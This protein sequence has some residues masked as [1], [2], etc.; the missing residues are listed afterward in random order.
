ML[1]QRMD[2]LLCLSID[3]IKLNSHV[4]L[5]IP[6]SNYLSC[7]FETF[8]T[9]GSRWR[10]KKTYSMT[11]MIIVICLKEWQNSIY[12]IINKYNHNNHNN[13]FNFILL[14]WSQLYLDFYV[15]IVT[16]HVGC[17]EE[18]INDNILKGGIK[19]T[20]LIYAMTFDSNNNI[21]GG[22]NKS[23]E[24]TDNKEIDMMWWQLL[25]FFFHR[26][27]PAIMTTAIMPV[28]LQQHHC[29]YYYYCQNFTLS[30]SLSLSV[31]CMK[32]L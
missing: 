17:V 12:P 9:I 10:K 2:K 3:T 11:I 31:E 5:C 6:S 7:S 20:L 16:Y 26:L 24:A 32:V 18:D 22:S 21:N 1:L 27:L 25:R 14:K 15:Y 29:K 4:S 19:A 30:Q 28:W 23:A 13:K 8:I